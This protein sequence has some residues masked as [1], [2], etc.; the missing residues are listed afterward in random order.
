MKVCAINILLVLPTWSPRVVVRGYT[1]DKQSS[2]YAGMPKSVLIPEATLG[3]NNKTSSGG[4]STVAAVAAV[5]AAATASPAFLALLRD[6][7][8]DRRGHV[9]RAQDPNLKWSLDSQPGT[10]LQSKMG[11]KSG[12]GAEASAG[13]DSE[14]AAD[15]E[16]GTNR[17]GGMRGVGCIGVAVLLRA[18]AGLLQ[19]VWERV[20]AAD[21][22]G[23]YPM[24][25][26][27][28]KSVPGDD[29]CHL[30]GKQS[31]IFD[32]SD[33]DALRVLAEELAVACRVAGEKRVLRRVET[34]SVRIF[35]RLQ[36][37]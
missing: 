16:R 25:T 30:T 34:T 33:V 4:C 23:G 10:G 3:D 12:V 18:G 35:A 31:G 20:R 5:A 6:A 24:D 22:A 32:P 27:S 37:V 1:M 2:S 7:V 26:Q 28:T 17:P 11:K 14:A 19:A 36:L 15:V 13:R 9:G 21:E 8:G 29:G